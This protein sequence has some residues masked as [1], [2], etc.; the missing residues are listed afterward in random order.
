MRFT[1][2]LVA[3]LG[4]MAFGWLSIPVVGHLAGVHISSTQ[5]ITMGA[6]FFVL[7]LAWLYALRVYFSKRKS[8]KN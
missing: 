4:I 5:G 1:E 6:Y 3:S 8:C 7:R 2:A